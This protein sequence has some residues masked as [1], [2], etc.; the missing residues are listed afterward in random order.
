MSTNPTNA[1]T[2]QP[3]TARR[4]AAVPAVDILETRDEFTLRADL[5][6]VAPD[7]LN[8]RVHG[9][10]L[11]IEGQRHEPEA[12]TVVERGYEALDFARTFRLPPGIDGSRIEARLEAGVLTLRLPKAESSKP[13]KI[14]VRAAS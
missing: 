12:G 6:G 4:Q 10:E 5:P 8:V 13:R 11:S 1:E 2:R 7:G 14:E 3:A 9:D